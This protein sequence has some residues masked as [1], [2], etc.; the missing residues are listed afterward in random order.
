MHGLNAYVSTLQVMS[1]DSSQGSEAGEQAKVASP[2]EDR[3]L[4]GKEKLGGKKRERHS[5]P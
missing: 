5:R 4:K 2:H 1:K 3:I